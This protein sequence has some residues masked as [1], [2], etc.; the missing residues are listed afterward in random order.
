MSRSYRKIPI[1]GNTY[2]KS[3]KSFKKQCSRA[4][5]R[6][7]SNILSQLPD[8]TPDINNVTIG[9]IGPKDGKQMIDPSNEKYEVYFRK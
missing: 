6:I 3:E 8:E 5:R 9:R 2:A 4:R 1:V 7:E